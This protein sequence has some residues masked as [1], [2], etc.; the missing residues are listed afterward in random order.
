MIDKTKYGVIRQ[1]WATG[2]GRDELIASFEFKHQAVTHLKTIA[3]Q[4]RTRHEI[5]SL[6]IVEVSK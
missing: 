2:S 6:E 3:A 1:G 4:F 5:I